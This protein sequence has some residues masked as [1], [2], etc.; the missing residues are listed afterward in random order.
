MAGVQ[1]AFRPSLRPLD[2]LPDH[3]NGLRYDRVYADLPQSGTRSSRIAI[4]AVCRSRLRAG[5]QAIGADEAGRDGQRQRGVAQPSMRPDFS[6]GIAPAL[7]SPCKAG[8]GDPI[9]VLD[10]VGS[11][12]SL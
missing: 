9:I 12:R 11:N 4:D 2:G 8:R 10:R 1:L 5:P 3:S 7:E 6:A